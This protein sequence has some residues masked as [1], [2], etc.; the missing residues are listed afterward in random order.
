MWLVDYNI[1]YTFSDFHVITQSLNQLVSDV[2]FRKVGWYER[3]T[4]TTTKTTVTSIHQ[5]R[6]NDMKNADHTRNAQND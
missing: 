1:C 5:I 3:E 2:Y 4:L 6:Y